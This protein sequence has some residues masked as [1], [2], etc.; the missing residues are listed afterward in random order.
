MQSNRVKNHDDKSTKNTFFF[1]QKSFHANGLIMANALV[2]AIK[3]KAIQF[4]YAN[5]EAKKLK[6]LQEISP[7]G[8]PIPKCSIIS[9]GIPKIQ[10]AKSNKAK[11]ITNTVES[12]QFLCR[13]CLL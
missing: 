11:L 3:P 7:E 1:V 4:P 5:I 6:N 12:I 8:H 10:Y 13:L 2:N 9:C